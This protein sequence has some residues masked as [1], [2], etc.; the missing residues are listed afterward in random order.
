MV[1][2]SLFSIEAEMSVL[3]SM[4]LS[5]SKAA[6]VSEILTAD[7]FYRP[8]HKLIWEAMQALLRKGREIDFVTLRA[9][10]AERGCLPDAG[11][12]DFLVEIAEYVPSAHHALDYAKI[13]Q[14]RKKRRDILAL[15][16]RFANLAKEEDDIDAV[17]EKLAEEVGNLDGAEDEFRFE[18]VKELT[19][20]IMDIVDRA[21]E[22]EDVSPFICS[23]GF[24][25]LDE[26][27]GGYRQGGFYGIAGRTGMGK[28]SIAMCSV[29]EAAKAGTP[30]LVITLE[31]P[32]EDLVRKAMAILGDYPGWMLDGKPKGK[33]GKLFSLDPDFYAK[34]ANSAEWLYSLPIEFA[35]TSVSF[36]MDDVRKA[37]SRMMRKYN[38]PCLVVL[39][40][41][42]LMDS[43]ARETRAEQ[44]N[45]ISK[46]IKRLA[47]RT[48]SA[49]IVLMQVNQKVDKQEDKVPEISDISDS[50]GMTKAADAIWMVH[51]PEYFEARK[52]RRREADTSEAKIV[53]RKGR[54]GEGSGEVSLWF[55]KKNTRFFEA[56]P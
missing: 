42:Q 16:E 19:K 34:V 6:E 50:S 38:K 55:Q 1:S 21:M 10:L 31:M 8:A 12:I 3:G 33:Q 15:S 41:V 47:N 32:P 25:E 20:N 17:A 13:V 45:I 52:E 46:Q 5:T 30:V 9:E 49:F 35:S 22:G 26:I 53:I 18:S 11:G 54:G 7:D 56:E 43:K 36:F 27:V 4:A 51:R 40:Y 37:I 2:Q 24:E 39:D 48:K 29:L 23:T 28:T 14:D 44:L